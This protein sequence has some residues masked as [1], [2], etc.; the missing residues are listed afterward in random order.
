MTQEDNQVFVDVHLFNFTLCVGDANGDTL[1]V[2]SF[3]TC[4]DAK[5]APDMI[6]FKLPTV[7]IDPGTR[8][9]MG[10]PKIDLVKRIP[11]AIEE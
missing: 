6:S 7:G 1:M 10:N 5:K 9:A 2:N 4:L 8:L 11:I 3:A